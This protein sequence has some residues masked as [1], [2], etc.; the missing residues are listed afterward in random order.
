MEIIDNSK[1]TLMKIRKQKYA[2]LP[3]VVMTWRNTRALIWLQ[4]YYHVTGTEYVIPFGM[5]AVDEKYCLKIGAFS[6]EF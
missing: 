1:Y 3:L 6:M 4:S 2:W 5:V